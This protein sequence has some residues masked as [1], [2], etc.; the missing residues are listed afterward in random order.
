[1]ETNTILLLV[2]ICICYLGIGFIFS[3]LIT[4]EANIMLDKEKKETSKTSLW[5][6]FTFIFLWPIVLGAYMFG[7]F[8]KL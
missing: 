4:I 1:M 2:L 7:A 6:R 8:N 5:E 3:I